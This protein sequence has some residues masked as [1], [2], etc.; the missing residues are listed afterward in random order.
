MSDKIDFRALTRN[1][2]RGEAEDDSSDT[3]ATDE[4]VTLLK[5]A[6]DRRLLIVHEAAR[7]KN[8]FNSAELDLLAEEITRF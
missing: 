1:F 8:T 6:V 2:L 3:P 5:E 7:L 4:G